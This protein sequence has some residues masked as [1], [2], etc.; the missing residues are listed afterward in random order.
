MLIAAADRWR[1]QAVRVYLCGKTGDVVCLL[2]VTWWSESDTATIPRPGRVS[3]YSAGLNGSAAKFSP[4]G[5]LAGKVT[6][7]PW[8]SQSCF[9]PQARWMMTVMNGWR[10]IWISRSPAELGSGKTS[11]HIY[12]WGRW[13]YFVFLLR[14]A[15][16]SLLWCFQVPWWWWGAII[17]AISH[18]F[19][20]LAGVQ[21][22]A[23]CNPL[24]DSPI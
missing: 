20:I 15:A 17:V 11:N 3:D 4:Q 13:S 14:C 21:P 23:G 16:A 2:S 10:M 19:I 18:I 24:L 22:H 12:T 9:S 1:W 5:S 8:S 7:C 6:R